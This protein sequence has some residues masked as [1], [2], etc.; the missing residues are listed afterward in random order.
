MNEKTN[1][2]ARLLDIMDRLRN[3]C[4]WDRKQTWDTLRSNTIEECFELCDAIISKDYDS[5]REELGDLLLHIVFYGKIAQEEGRFDMADVAKGI[6]DKLIFRHPHVFG[7]THVNDA[8]D[9]ARNWEQLKKQEKSDG[10]GTLS[11]VPKGLPAMIKAFRIQQKV[12]GVGFD[13]SD[14]RDVW[15][16]VKEEIGEFESEAE[17]SDRAEEEFGDL[18]FSLINAA[19]HYGIDPENALERCNRKFISRFE[20]LESLAQERDTPLR[21]LDIRQMEELWQM[22][23]KDEVIIE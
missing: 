16:K 12:A 15:A 13:W 4:P 14:K 9:V 5:I 8:G 6:C 10:K 21:E 23:K 3:E 18:I 19:R 22:A 2:Y 20:R 7:H 11:G 17:G 1:Q